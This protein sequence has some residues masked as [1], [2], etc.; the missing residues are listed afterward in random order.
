MTNSKRKTRSITV[1]QGILDEVARHLGISDEDASKIIVHRIDDI[2]DI[3][4]FK[5][6]KLYWDKPM[7]EHIHH[8]GK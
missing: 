5:E 2:R 7:H 8:F 6:K 4:R 1:S 3:V